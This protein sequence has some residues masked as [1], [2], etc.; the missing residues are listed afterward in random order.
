MKLPN[1]PSD[2]IDLAMFD[3][4]Q[5]EKDRRYRVEMSKWH[6]STVIG[7]EEIC[8]VCLAGSVMANSLGAI[9]GR[10]AC[11]QDYDEETAMA[12]DA[13]DCF[14]LGNVKEG[15]KWLGIAPSRVE[16]M[17]ITRY[18]RDRRQFRDDMDILANALRGVGL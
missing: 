6:E 3:L 2:L 14:R 15:V 16:D 17:V 11:P 18:E 5:I 10:E 4:E 7:G 1:K 12:L 9:H 13:L 8:E